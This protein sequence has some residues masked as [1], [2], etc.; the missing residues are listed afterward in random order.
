M[1]YRNK[2]YDPEMHD[3]WHAL[4]VKQPY[5]NDLVTEAY[6]DDNGIVYGIKSIEVRSRNT[7]YRGD[8]LICSSA[9]PVYPGMGCGVTLGLVELYNVKPI[10]EFTD[11][12]WACTRIPKEKRL[13]ITKGYGWMMR[14]PR[15]VVEMPIKGMLGIY[16]LVYTKGEIVQYPQ[17]MVIDKKSWEQI[18]KQ[19]QN[20]E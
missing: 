8:L 9:A 20:K 10:T 5:A 15:R 12:D 19:I 13:K 7:T 2:D 3:R 4:T 18:Q 1:Q 6:K 16:N 14:N 11:E 17:K